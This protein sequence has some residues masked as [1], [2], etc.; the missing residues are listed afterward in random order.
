MSIGYLNSLCK[1]YI[2]ISFLSLDHNK[3][4]QLS[5]LSYYLLI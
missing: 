3:F 4:I 5:D 2:I 1:F